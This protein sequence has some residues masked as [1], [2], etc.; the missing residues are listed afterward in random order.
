MDGSRARRPPCLCEYVTLNCGHRR[1]VPM[2]HISTKY[3]FRLTVGFPRGR[4][5]DCQCDT[6]VHC[7][8]GPLHRLYNNDGF[9]M[10]HRSKSLSQMPDWVQ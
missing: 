4:A 8:R 1:W 5:N 3:E 9:R 2:H 7:H 6:G 10:T